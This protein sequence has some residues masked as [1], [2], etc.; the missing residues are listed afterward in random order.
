[1]MTMP[2]NE[3]ITEASKFFKIY[4]KGV[5]SLPI[6]F[7]FVLES[8]KPQIRNL[9]AVILKRSV[10]VNFYKIS[11][12]DKNWVKNTILERFFLEK[13]A[14]VRTA[15]GHVV[16]LLTKMVFEKEK[17]WNE[18]LLAISVK[19]K[20]EETMENRI[21]G[22]TLL[23]LTLDTSCSFLQDHLKSLA[24]FLNENLTENNDDLLKETI[25]CLTI[26]I[27]SCGHDDEQAAAFSELIPIVIKAVDSL[28]KKE[29]F[30]EGVVY[31]V[32]ETIAVQIEEDNMAIDKYIV[33]I[34]K[35][36]LSDSILMNAKL[37][38]AFKESALEIFVVISDHKRP[39]FTK[40]LELL[41]NLVVV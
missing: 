41:K 14:N 34:V 17:Q 16:G 33:D 8:D 13:S 19:T 24:T 15:I 32:F 1:M 29:E 5:F 39:V 23:R 21:L 26:I 36:I 25:K 6:L 18:L 12:E 3:A 38:I 11:D 30:D 20:K 10:V 4:V 28:L 37:P 2:S 40:N 22:T 27:E 7:K 9:A 31:Q 35:Y